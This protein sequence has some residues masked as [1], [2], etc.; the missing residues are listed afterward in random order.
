MAERSRINH[1]PMNNAF[2]QLLE[3]TSTFGSRGITLHQMWHSLE[4]DGTM[5]KAF[6]LF[7]WQNLTAMSCFHFATRIREKTHI[8]EW[9]SI[10]DIEAK[11]VYIIANDEYID[12][13]L[14]SNRR[15]L[16]PALPDNA[17]L[18]LE[19]IAQKSKRGITQ[20]ELSDMLKMDPRTTYHHVE[21]LSKYHLIVKFPVVIPGI[22]TNMCVLPSHA[23]ALKEKLLENNFDASSN[24]SL[25][26]DYVADITKLLSGKRSVISYSDI[27]ANLVY[28]L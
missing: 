11:S 8:V 24:V 3:H 13:F 22:K 9:Q 5:D 15:S 4:Y 18:I 7:F 16:L 19:K 25:S 1:N 28:L 12:Q 6:K 14:Y 2:W 27:K 21:T 17:V 20:A 10:Q 23:E 26:M